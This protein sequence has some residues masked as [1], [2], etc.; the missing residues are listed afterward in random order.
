MVAISSLGGRRLHQIPSGNS[1][2]GITTIATSQNDY[3]MMINIIR[4]P[5]IHMCMIYT[6]L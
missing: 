1:N 2:D 3:S 4:V 6:K 5:V